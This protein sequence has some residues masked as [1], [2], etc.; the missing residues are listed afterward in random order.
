MADAK[1]S[2][3]T[4]RVSS[5][6]GDILYMDRGGADEYILIEDLGITGTFI[7]TIGDGTNAYTGVTAAGYYERIGRMVNLSCNIS[8]T[9]IGAAGATVLRIGAFPITTL[10][11]A[12]YRACGNLGK[13]SGIDN[14]GNKQIVIYTSNNLD[15]VSFYYLN[16]NAAETAILANSSSTSGYISFSLSYLAN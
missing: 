4:A 12:S 16:D 7:P 11:G 14:N 5:S 13:V 15:Y 1:V 2:A 9:G 10:N 8:W 3:G 6:T